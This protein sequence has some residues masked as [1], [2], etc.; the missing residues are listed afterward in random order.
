MPKRGLLP[1]YIYLI[2]GQIMIYPR[3]KKETFEKKAK[4]C[5][6]VPSA[7]K[8]HSDSM[9]DCIETYGLNLSHKIPMEHWK[10]TMAHIRK[11]NRWIDVMNNSRKK[12]CELINCTNHP[13]IFELLSYVSYIE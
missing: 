5:M 8:I 9:A 12:G 10:S 6:R 4:N 2:E 3:L 11:I 1:N 7:V 13:H